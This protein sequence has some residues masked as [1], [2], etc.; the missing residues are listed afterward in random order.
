[1][2]KIIL[3]LGCGSGHDSGA[4]LLIGDQLVAA[5]EEER[6]NRQKHYGNFP[7]KSINF[8]L[9]SENIKK[10]K[11]DNVIIGWTPYGNLFKKIK[12]LINSPLSLGT[13][14]RRV[15]FILLLHSKQ[16][17]TII[18]P[19]FQFI[20]YGSVVSNLGLLLNKY[21]EPIIPIFQVISNLSQYN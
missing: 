8:C 15:K 17:S 16:I 2:K 21:G 12:F 19:L 20:K 5:I 7:Y 11:V 10:E 1:M 9:E 3:G 14:K 4:A 6:L 13:S 18:I